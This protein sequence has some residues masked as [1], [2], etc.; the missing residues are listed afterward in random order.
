MDGINTCGTITNYFW[1][2]VIMSRSR[3][4]YTDYSFRIEIVC[5]SNHLFF[6]HVCHC[7]LLHQFF[8]FKRLRQ[9]RCFIL[10]GIIN[11]WWFFAPNERARIF[12]LFKMI[13][14]DIFR[15]FM[16]ISIAFLLRFYGFLICSLSETETSDQITLSASH[17]QRFSCELFILI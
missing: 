11:N 12:F 4:H 14:F 17:R 7:Q 3:S 1:W 16:S 6:Y 9:F 13:H 5:S 15:P 8:S 2:A 10:N